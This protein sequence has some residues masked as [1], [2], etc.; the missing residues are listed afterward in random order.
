MVVGAVHLTGEVGGLARVFRSKV[1]TGMRAVE[2]HVGPA[3]KF[4]ENPVRKGH[5]FMLNVKPYGRLR[6]EPYS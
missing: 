3:A 4:L 1:A 6:A 5:G 2:M